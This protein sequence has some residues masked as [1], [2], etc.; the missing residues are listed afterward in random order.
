MCVNQGGGCP[1]NMCVLPQEEAVL[2]MC[3][4]SQEKAVHL[5]YM[6]F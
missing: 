2:I 5:I 6:L 4:L 3:V 1:S